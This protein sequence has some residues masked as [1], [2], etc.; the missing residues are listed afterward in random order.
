[1]VEG[2]SFE[3]GAGQTVAIVGESGSGKSVTARALVGLAGRGSWATAD[4]L[5][6]GGE[7]VVGQSAAHWRRIRGG[8]VGLVV[9][10]A[11]VSL[12]PLRPVGR[13]I[14]DALRLHTRLS[15]AE[16][17]ARSVELLTS[18]GMPDPELRLRQRSGELSGGLRQRALIAS[19]LAAGPP[20]LIADEP[21]TALDSTVQ[22]QILALFESIAA[23]GTGMLFISHD[24]AVVSRLADE[25]LVMRAGRIVERGPTEAVLLDPQHE[26]TKTLLRAVPTGVPR[27]T[28]LSAA[29]AAGAASPA[30]ATPGPATRAPA[31]RAPAA[32]AAATLAP[33]APAHPLLDIRG[34]SKSFGS[35]RAVDGVTLTLAPGQTLGLVGESGSGKTTLARLV[36]G[37][38]TPD[39][40]TVAFDGEPWAPLRERDRRARRPLLGTV[41]QDALSS[42]DPRL[43]VGRILTDAQGNGAERNAARAAQRNGAQDGVARLL[44]DVGLSP[45]LADARPLHLSGGQRQ[46]VSIARALAPEP[47]LIV[48]DEPVSA[49]DVSIQ[50]QILDLLDRLQRERGVAY[51]F[52]S[53]DLG[54]VQHMSDTIAV[55]RDGRIVEQ[56]ASAS[57]FAAPADPYTSAL[58]AAAPRLPARPATGA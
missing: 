47:R 42:F 14:G 37:L 19:A 48:L 36:L 54:V 4:V 20:L 35:R 53:H 32:R 23:Q 46:R 24:L 10:D 44:S 17:H 2:V 41:Y 3:V 56:G 40:G 9:Q 8:E 39:G 52:I 1:V 21:T 31:T 34:V 30:P 28:A 29:G 50:A 22:A 58:L 51:L 33:A 25:V 45:D 13:E 55:M 49:L 38:E 12:D 57:V 27:G 16:R 26:Y 11:L 5:E 18:V 43:T 15:A 6:V 7:S